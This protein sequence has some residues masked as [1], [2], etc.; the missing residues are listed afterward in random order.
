MQIYRD[1]EGMIFKEQLLRWVKPLIEE[2][3]L[4]QNIIAL[5]P[6]SS[7]S[8]AIPNKNIKLLESYPL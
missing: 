3:I 5:G 6:G 8:K 4:N 7:G 2:Y 1:D